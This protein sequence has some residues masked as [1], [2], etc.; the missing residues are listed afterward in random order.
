[1]NA[2]NEVKMLVAKKGVTLT[3]LA[4]YLTNH[5]DKKYTIDTCFSVPQKLLS[6]SCI[7]TNFVQGYKI[8]FI[9]YDCKLFFRYKLIFLLFFSVLFLFYQ[10]FSVKQEKTDGIVKNFQNSFSFI[11]NEES[12]MLY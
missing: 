8:R 11:C 7:Y 1:M 9:F 2:I 12:F 6:A 4:E 5:S 10:D 3:Y